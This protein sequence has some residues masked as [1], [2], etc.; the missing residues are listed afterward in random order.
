MNKK[1][2]LEELG[3]ALKGLPEEDV[4]ERLAFYGEM[5][6]DRM[7]EGK[8]EEEAV[9]EAGSIKDI[10]SQTLDE[11]PLSK[12]V[13][14]SVK[15]KRALET[16]ETVLIIVGS[17]V[18][19]PLLIALIA[20]TFALYIVLWSLVLVVWAVFTTFAVSS[21]GCLAFGVFRFASG[22]APGGLAFTGVCLFLAGLSI[23]LFFASLGAT[24]GCAKLTKLIARG[25][26]SLLSG[27]RAEK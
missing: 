14:K 4:K 22:D 1:E 19:V 25:I 5:I 10:V 7:E 24:K 2:F 12:I 3:G 6:D 8:T 17:P 21:L 16:W 20:L 23:L 9:A 18:W 27:R 26:K 11:I 13:K 15:P